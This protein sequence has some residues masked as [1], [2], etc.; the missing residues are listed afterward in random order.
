MKLTT[1]DLKAIKDLMGVT[2][3]EKNEDFVKKEDIK[4]LPTKDE[5]YTETSKIYKKLKDI[6]DEMTVMNHQISRNSDN[7]EENRSSI[8]KL[9]VKIA[10]N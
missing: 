8:K 9:E 6:E 5:F 3:D 1:E 2:F 4:H 10:A 7:I